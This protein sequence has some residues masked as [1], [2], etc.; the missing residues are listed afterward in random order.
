VPIGGCSD[1]MA[2]LTGPNRWCRSCEQGET[3]ALRQE[4]TMTLTPRLL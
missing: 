3:D 4:V 2:V 1:L